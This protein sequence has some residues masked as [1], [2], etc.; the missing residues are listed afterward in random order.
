MSRLA[1]FLFF[2]SVT[3]TFHLI[4]VSRV[5]QILFPRKQKDRR[6]TKIVN[7]RVERVTLQSLVTNTFDVPETKGLDALTTVRTPE[8]SRGLKEEE[9]VCEDGPC[10][11]IKTQ[12]PSRLSRT[13]Q[14]TRANE[15]TEKLR[16][17]KRQ[18]AE[19]PCL[20]KDVYP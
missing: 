9:A 16:Q 5:V 1:A 15:R 19:A 13:S 20:F 14:T 12:P 18:K 8:F 17:Q 7:G 11:W 4:S 10:I 6:Q 2:H 3:A